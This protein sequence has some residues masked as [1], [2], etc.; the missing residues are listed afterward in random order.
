MGGLI[1]N[2]GP[3]DGTGYRF[4]EPFRRGVTW[5]VAPMGP[6][7]DTCAALIV[8]L[9]GTARENIVRPVRTARHSR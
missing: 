4:A 3:G 5:H 6:S 1:P 2:P 7:D 9:T 8:I